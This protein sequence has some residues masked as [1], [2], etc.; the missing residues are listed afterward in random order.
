[1]SLDPDPPQQDDAI[2]AV[3][4]EA[5]RQVDGTGRLVLDPST[6]ISEL[7]L[8]SVAL[9]EMVAH[10][11]Q[12]LAV[13]IPDEELGSARSIGELIHAVEKLRS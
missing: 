13:R 7:G 11:E 12:Q 9:L 8:D 10:V 5:L 3:F 6:E 4:R 1:M 2:I